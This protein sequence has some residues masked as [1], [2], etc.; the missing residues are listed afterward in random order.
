[1]NISKIKIFIKKYLPLIVIIIIMTILSIICAI[2]PKDISFYIFLIVFIVSIVLRI[3]LEIISKRRRIKIPISDKTSTIIKLY[4]LFN[5]EN[6][7]TLVVI[8]TKEESIVNN[9]K[10]L[11]PGS[12]EN[13]HKGTYSIMLPTN[14]LKTIKLFLE[15]NS[16]ERIIIHQFVTKIEDN[17]KRINHTLSICIDKYLIVQY[18]KDIFSKEEIKNIKKKLREE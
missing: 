15:N 8:N 10:K 14:N 12:R 3:I 5:L 13:N 7:N 17:S 9:A 11:F 6:T 16:P 2:V 4:E 1:M 18:R